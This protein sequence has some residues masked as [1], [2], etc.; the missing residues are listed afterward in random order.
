MKCA[1]LK[2]K[3]ERVELFDVNNEIGTPPA[4]LHKEFISSIFIAIPFL[5][6]ELTC[7]YTLD[8]YEQKQRQGTPSLTT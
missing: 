2:H 6:I 4:L 7:Q 8:G 5:T 3:P 1:G